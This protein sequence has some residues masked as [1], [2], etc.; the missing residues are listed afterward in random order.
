MIGIRGDFYTPS[1]FLAQR[2]IKKKSAGAWMR[3]FEAK[4]VAVLDADWQEEI[5]DFTGCLHLWSHTYIQQICFPTSFISKIFSKHNYCFMTDPKCL[6]YLLRCCKTLTQQRR[7]SCFHCN[8][9]LLAILLCTCSRITGLGPAETLYYLDWSYRKRFPYFVTISMLYETAVLNVYD[10][11]GG[12]TF[13][14]TARTHSMPPLLCGHL[15]T[16]L[17]LTPVCGPIAQCSNELD[18]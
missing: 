11:H 10:F 4:I 3:A 7:H 2:I 12:L 17:L 5:A 9:S 6:S 8:L 15:M 16:R 18:L 13:I 1:L 14:S